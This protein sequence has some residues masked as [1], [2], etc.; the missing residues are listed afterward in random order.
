MRLG[1]DGLRL[2]SKRLGVGRYIEY[3]LRYWPEARNPFTD[4]VVYTPGAIPTP[5]PLRA[6]IRVQ[7]LAPALPPAAWEHAVLPLRKPHDDVFFCPSYVVPLLSRVHPVIVTH[8]G[9]YEALPSAFP[10]W[11]RTRARFVYQQSCRRAD[12]VITVSESSRADI[13]RF[14]GVDP[15]KIRVIPE[16]VD[17]AFVPIDDE[18]R[19]AARRRSYFPDGRPFVLFVGK[20]TARRHIPDLV[21]A[22][23]RI[24]RRTKLPHGLVLLGPDTVGHSLPQRFAT[25]GIADRVVHRDFA[26]HE[27]LVEAYN[28]ADVFIY[29]SD[30][31]GFGIPV[32][33]AIACGTPAI[34]LENSAFPE[35]AGGIAHF[36]R[37]GSPEALEEALM[38][39][40][41]ARGLRASVR[42][43]GPVRAEAY[44]WRRI[45][46]RTMDVLAE[47]AN[48]R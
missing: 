37:D 28:A 2:M 47:F 8:H 5:L 30:Y 21:E 22:F 38:D 20:M 36:A 48:G 33:E 6:P 1:I 45:A 12:V 3:M 23:A 43:A 25:L 18:A 24:T 13:V 39:V 42:R 15:A 26:S 9:S 14:Y 41:N 4:I 10:W 27:E 31:E 19:L 35:F 46:Y 17:E 40:L 34:T 44:H 16:G 29:P 7:S 11:P 32:L